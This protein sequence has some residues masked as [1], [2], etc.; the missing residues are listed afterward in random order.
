MSDEFRNQT[1]RIADLTR[2]SDVINGTT[3]ENCSLIGPAVIVL[4]DSYL[5][6]CTYIGQADAMFW[7]VTGRTAI[8]GAVAFRNCTMVACDLQRIG[9][10]DDAEGIAKMRA[11]FTPRNPT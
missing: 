9:L 5:K 8:M 1:I 4:R 2:T 11:A 10:A 7:D 3:F 6:D